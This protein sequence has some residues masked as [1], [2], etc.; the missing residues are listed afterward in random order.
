MKRYP[1]DTRFHFN[2]W[3]FGCEVRHHILRLLII[4]DP[5]SHLGNLGRFGCSLQLADPPNSL[6]LSIIQI[7]IQSRAMGPRSLLIRVWIR[8]FSPAWRHNHQPRC[9]DPFMWA[10]APM[11]RTE[12]WKCRLHYP[13]RRSYWRRRTYWRGHRFWRLLV[14]TRI[15]PWS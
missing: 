13:N 7:S 8:E 12:W 1:E 4:C 15:T 5:K 11:S 10:W 14:P 6:S 9:P 2:T 3:T